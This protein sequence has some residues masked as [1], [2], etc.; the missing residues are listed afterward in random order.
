MPHFLKPAPPVV[1]AS[2]SLHADQASRLLLEKR[3]QLA[4][5]ELA[6]HENMTALIDTVDLK[7]TLCKVDTDR[8]KL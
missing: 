6:T 2:T 7:D 3:E 5:T 4:S 1:S 8:D